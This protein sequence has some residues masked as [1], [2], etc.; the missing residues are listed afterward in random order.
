MSNNLIV[1]Y[2]RF[3]AALEKA[4]SLCVEGADISTICGTIDNFIEEELKKTFSNKKSKKLE[5]GIAMPTCISVN[6]VMG[7]YSPCPDDSTTLKLE[8]LVSVELGAHIDG[9][10]ANA[11]TTLVIGGKAKEKKADVLKAAYDS[12]LA[13]TRTIKVGS[14]NQDVTANIAK[15]CEAYG[16]EPVQGVLSHKVKKHLIDGNEVIINKATAEQRVDDWEF[17]PGDVI[18]LE[19]FA[20]TGDGMGR[21]ADI[22]TTVY[23]REMDMQYN[24]KSKSARQFFAVVN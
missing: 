20:S 1:S 12:F 5:R 2:F 18:A 24:L 17:V 11:G 22:R 13:A 7:H 6:E 8:D 15:V 9:Y 4:V 23:K 19:V 14:T 21:E 16:V 10:A 3:I